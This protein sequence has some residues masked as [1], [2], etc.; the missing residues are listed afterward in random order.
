M[1]IARSLEDLNYPG[2]S[3]HALKGRLKSHYAVT[4]SGNWRVTFRINAEEVYDVD[5]LDYHQIYK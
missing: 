1:T 3:L 4:V 2:S 5:Y